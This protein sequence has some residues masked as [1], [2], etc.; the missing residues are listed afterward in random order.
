MKQKQTLLDLMYYLTNKLNFQIIV[1][2]CYRPSMR[3]R[4]LDIGQ[5]LFCV[6]IDR[7]EAEVKKNAK[8]NKAIIHLDLTSL[9]NKGFING[10]KEN[11]YL[12]EEHGKS[13]AGKI[14]PSCLFGLPIRMQDSLHLACSWI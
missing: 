3:S 12:G 8:K 10:Q 2:P 9:I 14:G 11:V 1:L 7:D 4:W 6:F 13:Q 5:V